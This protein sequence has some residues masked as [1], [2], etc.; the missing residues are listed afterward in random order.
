MLRSA[1]SVARSFFFAALC[2]ALTCSALQAQP[3]KRIAVLDFAPT[4]GGVAPGA[5]NLAAEVLEQRLVQDGHYSMIERN[6][7]DKILAE[8]NFANSDRVDAATA[9]K[10]GKILGVGAVIF[11]S[12][13][14]CNVQ[15]QQVKTATTGMKPQGKATCNVSAKVVDTTTAEILAAASSDGE[16]KLK[17]YFSPPDPMAILREAMSNAIDGVFFQMDKSPKMAKLRSGDDSGP[18]GDASGQVADVS[19]DELV[20][21]MNNTSGIQVGQVLEISRVGR[22]I[23]DPTTNQVVKTIRDILGEAK[24]TE[25]EAKSVTATF[26]GKGTP[27]RGDTARVK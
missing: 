7:I 18:S 5:G 14:Q 26:H 24:V 9:A 22:T 2:L 20:I 10:I 27:Q 3:N 12:V 23:T 15:F 17:V 21:S 6:G 4:T 1:P 11:G 13:A 16:T 25:V 19:G 8:Q